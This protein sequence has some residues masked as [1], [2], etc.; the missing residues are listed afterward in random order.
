MTDKTARL[1]AIKSL[2]LANV[3]YG[4]QP[5]RID[6]VALACLKQAYEQLLALNSKK[7]GK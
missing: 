5:F 6:K 2:K 3:S 7:G 1:K 4:E